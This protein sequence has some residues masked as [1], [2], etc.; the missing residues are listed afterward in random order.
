LLHEHNRDWK[1]ADLSE[2]AGVAPSYAH[3]ICQTLEQQAF[4]CSEGA[5]PRTIRRLTEPGRLLD[6]WADHQSLQAYSVQRFYL[7]TPKN[8]LTTET[9]TEAFQTQNIPSALTAVSAAIRRAPFVSNETSTTL[10]A[11][12]GVEI[13]IAAVMEKIGASHVDEGENVLVLSTDRP[14]PF[15]FKQR[16]DGLWLASDLQ[17]YLDLY[18][19]PQRGK[20]Q[21]EHLRRQRLNY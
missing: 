7:W 17:I 9:V 14:S 15:M 8:S 21:A 20:E 5:G 3:K 16:V 6:E 12:T 4:M 18:A 10:L 1:I 13:E 2:V 11:P 19:W